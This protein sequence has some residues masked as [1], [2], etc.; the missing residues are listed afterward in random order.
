M[1]TI[2]KRRLRIRY[3]LFETDSYASRIYVYEIDLPGIINNRMLYNDGNYGFIYLGFK[4][5]DKVNLTLKYSVI[6]KDSD[7]AKR[8]GCQLDARL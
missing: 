8:F 4:P 2:R 7:S 1:I 3:G 6:N 5:I